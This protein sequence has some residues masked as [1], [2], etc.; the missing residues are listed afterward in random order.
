MHPV[1]LKIP[2]KPHIKAFLEFHFGADYTLSTNDFLGTLLFHLLKKQ[3]KI[4]DKKSHAPKAHIYT[5][6]FIVLIPE[7]HCFH[8]TVNSLTSLT[9]VHFNNLMDSMISFYFRGFVKN[10]INNPP[11]YK[12]DAILNFMD[13]NG[14]GEEHLT[15]DAFIK[16]Y[17]RFEKRSEELKM[18][19]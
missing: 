1:P 9:I 13:A 3:T 12:K 8:N 4:Y 7:W 14:I 10:L 16:A 5:D 6:T 18:G 15:E 19:N 2:C 11:K 17:H